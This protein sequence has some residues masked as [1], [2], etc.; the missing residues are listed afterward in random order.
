MDIFIEAQYQWKIL[1]KASRRSAMKVS[2]GFDS[3]RKCAKYFLHSRVILIRYAT[4]R[5]I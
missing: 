2:G 3:S 1:R 4:L 5:R